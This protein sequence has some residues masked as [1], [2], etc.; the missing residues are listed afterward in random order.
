[1]SG[2]RGSA[3]AN[4]IRHP[5]QLN[6]GDCFTYAVA[7]NHR[8]AL[9]FKGD[10]FDKTDIRGTPRSAPVRGSIS[11]LI[12][13]HAVVLPAP[14]SPL[15]T[16]IGQGTPGRSAATRK[17][18]M[19]VQPWWSTLR[20]GRSSSRLPPDSGAGSGREPRVR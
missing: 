9:L 16:R 19:S 18:L 2:R 6:L 11:A 12:I 5:A 14:C 13:L 1:M 15:A 8:R 3:G 20:K 4:V 17:A 10:D 7:K